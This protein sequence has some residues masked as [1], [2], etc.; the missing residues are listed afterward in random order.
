MNASQPTV[1]YQS[2]HAGSPPVINVGRKKRNALYLLTNDLFRLPNHWNQVWQNSNRNR[3]YYPLANTVP[4]LFFYG[5]VNHTEALGQS[6]QVPVSFIKPPGIPEY[7]GQPQSEAHAVMVTLDDVSV[8]VADAPAPVT[9][10]PA[11][12]TVETA[13]VPDS[14]LRLE[15]SSD[16]ESLDKRLENMHLSEVIILFFTPAKIFTFWPALISDLDQQA[17]IFFV[18]KLFL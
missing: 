2:Y 9:E 8:S 15:F 5:P 6:S 14:L 3:A 11:P 16:R 7:N 13:S 17:K 12:V 18:K 4:V 1:T 10:I